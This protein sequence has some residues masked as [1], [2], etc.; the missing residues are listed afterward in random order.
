MEFKIPTRGLFGYRNEFLTDTRGE[1]LISR[2]FAGYEP[3]RGEVQGRSVGALVCKEAG[4]TTAYSLERL[5]E[6]A[7]LFAGPGLEVYGGMI[8]GQNSR[9]NDVVVNPC[10]KKHLTNMRAATADIAVKLTPPR[11]MTLEAA[12][13][14]IDDDELVEVTPKSIRLRKRVLD[15]V[16]RRAQEKRAS[17]VDD[18]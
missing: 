16:R 6:R 2:L 15:N 8:V 10:V 12:I 11:R 4:S 17:I 5:E 14:W 18:D 3:F 7:I 9:E 1:G 13:E